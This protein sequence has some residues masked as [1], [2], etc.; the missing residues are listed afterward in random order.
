[1][2]ELSHTAEKTVKRYLHKTARKEKKN[3]S[4]KMYVNGSDR[5]GHINPRS[6][7]I[8]RSIWADV[9]ITVSMSVRTAVFRTRKVS[10]TI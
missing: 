5:K 8:F 7:V 9:S 10:E 2:I 4:I 1:M 3:M 6:T